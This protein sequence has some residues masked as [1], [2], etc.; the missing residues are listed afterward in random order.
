MPI[1]PLSF[2]GLLERTARFGLSCL[3][4]ADNMPLHVNDP[5]NLY[6]MASLASKLGISIEVGARGLTPGKLEDYLSIA[7]VFG[8]PVIRYVID[9]PG[10]EPTVEEIIRVIR[11]AL[12]S[13]KEAGI[14]LAIENHDRLKA[15][16]FDLI[17]RATDPDWVG[18]CLDSVN[19]LGAGE[20]L[21]TII[22]TLAWNTINL[23][24]KDFKVQRIDHKMGFVVE[25]TPAGKGQL[26]IPALVRKISETGKCQSAILELWTPPAANLEET[27]ERED[28]WARQSVSFLKTVIK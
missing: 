14:K 8:S 1:K 11:N 15:K 5:E 25:G 7:T 13:L 20:G 6:C 26:E 28:E 4:I 17:V 3:Q 22:E 16:D 24:L 27:I 12:P 23:H 19:S 10:Y 2:Q 18:I 9:E 21:E